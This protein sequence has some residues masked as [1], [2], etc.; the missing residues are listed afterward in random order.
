VSADNLSTLDEKTL[1]DL[2]A[3]DQDPNGGGSHLVKDLIVI[4]HRVTPERLARLQHALATADFKAVSRVAH[5]MK[6]SCATL[7]AFRMQA[8]CVELEKAGAEGDLPR[9]TALMSGMQ[10]EYAALSLLLQSFAERLHEEAVAGG[11]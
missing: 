6:S 3:C 9:V 5:A 7:G 8:L 2:H 1:A 10:A 11:E 4:F